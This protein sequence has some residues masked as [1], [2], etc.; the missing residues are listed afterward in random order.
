MPCFLAL[1][2]AGIAFFAWAAKICLTTIAVLFQNTE[3][4]FLIAGCNNGHLLFARISNGE[5]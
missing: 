2:V 1:C 3:N 4:V 5:P